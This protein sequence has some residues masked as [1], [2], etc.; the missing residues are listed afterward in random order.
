MAKLQYGQLPTFIFPNIAS[1][2]PLIKETNAFQ[3]QNAT[4]I[5]PSA[6]IIP[7]EVITTT[8]N[9]KII[10]AHNNNEK[11]LLKYSAKMLIL[12]CRVNGFQI[13]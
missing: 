2:N 12:L 13:D 11:M 9:N 4:P 6:K 5:A 10:N 7:F 1:I 8:K 3:P